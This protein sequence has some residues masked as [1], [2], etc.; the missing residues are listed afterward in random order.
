M[1]DNVEELEQPA[2]PTPQQGCGCGC[3]GAEAEETDA[4]E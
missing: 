3:M 2:E 4:A 1:S